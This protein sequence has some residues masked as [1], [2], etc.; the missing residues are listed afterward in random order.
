M[1]QQIFYLAMTSLQATI[2]RATAAANNLAN[3]DT[4]A[5]KAQKTIFEA[6]PLYGQGQPDRV[7]VAATAD[8]ADFRSGPLETTGRN[9]DVAVQGQGWIA[10]QGADGNTALTRNGSLSISPAGMLQDSAGHAVLGDGFSPIVLPPLQSVTIG[11]DGTISGALK[12]QTPSQITALA[13]I[14]LVNPPAGALQRRADGLFTDA[15]APLQPDSDV[16]LQVGA[17]EGSNAETTTMMM[18]MIETTRSFQMEIQ[19]MRMV[20]AEGQ[21]PSSPLT[22]S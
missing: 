16:R 15:S 13:R 4:V 19:L 3:R 1:S 18:N 14:M 5:F 6:L 21:G 9:L 12:G 7:M 17:L 10:V 2:D 11:A 22:L 8:G 20:M